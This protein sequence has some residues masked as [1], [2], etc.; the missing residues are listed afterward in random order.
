MNY[1]FNSSLSS[2]LSQ[3]RYVQG[4]K[5]YISEWLVSLTVYTN[6]RPLSLSRL[7]DFTELE[8]R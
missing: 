8:I 5:L 4:D 1:L 7:R 2:D 6:S 3:A